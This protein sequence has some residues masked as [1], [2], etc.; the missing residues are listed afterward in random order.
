MDSDLVDESSPSC[1]RVALGRAGQPC[2]RPRP[3]LRPAWFA[4][5][6]QLGLASDPVLVYVFHMMVKSDVVDQSPEL[7]ETAKSRAMKSLEELLKP[8]YAEM[9]ANRRCNQL[10]AKSGLQTDSDPEPSSR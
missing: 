2:S 5:Q 4:A 8:L 9:E 6:N 3:D 1:E 7:V 10:L